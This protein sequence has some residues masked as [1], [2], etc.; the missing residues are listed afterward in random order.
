M[1]QYKEIYTLDFTNVEH[2]FEFH[3]IIKK[4]LAFPDYYGCNRDAFWDCLRDMIG[5]PLHIEIKGLDNIEY[6]FGKNFTNTLI[7]I[8]K[9][10]KHFDNIA[11]L[12]K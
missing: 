8:L 10:A 4:E 9:R 2:Y 12:T 7:K 3:Y 1:Y 11:M 5:D 6:K